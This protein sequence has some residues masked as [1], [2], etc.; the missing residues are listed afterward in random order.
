MRAAGKVL[1]LVLAVFVVLGLGEW[2]VRAFDLGPDVGRLQVGMI[3]LTPDPDLRYELVPGYVS[4]L[5]D[6]AIN[7]QGLRDRPV[8]LAKPAGARRIACIGDSI[9]FG[10]GA[11]QDP[12]DVQLEERLAAGRP[13]GAPAIDV[14]NFG[15][16]GYNVGQI[17]A[18]LE[19]RAA[20]FAPDLVVYLY[21]L[22]DPQETS[23]ELE[24]TLRRGAGSP[25]RQD[26]VR[27]RWLASSSA[28]GGSRLWLLAR[29]AGTARTS[30]GENGAAEPI[31]DD[32]SIALAGG[33]PDYYRSLYRPGPARE[34]FEAGMATIG[35][36]SAR[37]GV[38]V[39]VATVPLFE[40]LWTYPLEDLHAQVRAAAESNGL[41]ALDL[42][43]AYQAALLAGRADFRADPLHPNRAGYGL[44]AEAVAAEIRNRGWLADFG[45]P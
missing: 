31:R 14:L 24:T 12:F 16:P 17:A 13:S 32:M 36:W 23:R 26:Y 22:N 44:A 19:K 40:N 30:R 38:P 35:R 4:P 9:A 20:A 21:C 8:E 34:R 41:A 18:A 2:A 25:A 3:R 15:V 37:T 5:R 1:L 10:M 28:L 43:P 42:L 7:A 33:A 11:A 39:L 29:L 6:V 27:R 45:R